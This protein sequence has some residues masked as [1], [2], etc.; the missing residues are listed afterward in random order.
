MHA[1][2]LLCIRLP[3]WFVE[4]ADVSF[5]GL[6]FQC[7]SNP[8]IILIILFLIVYFSNSVY[9]IVYIQFLLLFKFRDLKEI[10]NILVW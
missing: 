3:T 4:A 10:W 8:F 2:C 9:L 1:W 5:W 7:W 6:V